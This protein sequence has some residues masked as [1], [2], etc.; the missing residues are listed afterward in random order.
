MQDI[1]SCDWLQV[2]TVT[3]HKTLAKN[4]CRSVSERG[5]EEK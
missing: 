4:F 2:S 1:E 5:G 3:T